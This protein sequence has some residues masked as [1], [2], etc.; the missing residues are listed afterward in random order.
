MQ[1]LNHITDNQESNTTN[2]AKSSPSF[3]SQSRKQVHPGSCH[4]YEVPMHD[5]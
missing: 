3:S 4:L 5:Q 1:T 2:P